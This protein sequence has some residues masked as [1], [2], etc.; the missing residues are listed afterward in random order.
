[1][2]N[3]TRQNLIEQLTVEEKVALSTGKGNWNTRPVDRL[4]VSSVTMS[5]GPVGLRR[6]RDGGTLPAVAFPSVAKLACSFDVN[7]PRR[8]RKHITCSR[9]QYQ[10]RPALRT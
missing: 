10:A 2:D 1:M 8:K 9:A 5:D 3:N 6:E 4:N 7:L